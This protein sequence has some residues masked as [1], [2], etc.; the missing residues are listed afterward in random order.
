MNKIILISFIIIVVFV[1]GCD[2][3]HT[4]FDGNKETIC[5]QVCMTENLQHSRTSETS[6]TYIC[7]C[8]KKII[9]SKQ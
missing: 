5:Q 7:T 6:T 9:F 2:I 8:E 4:S 1:S 3:E